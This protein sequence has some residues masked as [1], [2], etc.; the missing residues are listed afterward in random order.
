MDWKKPTD[1]KINKK[2]IPAAKQLQDLINNL[3]NTIKKL[4]KVKKGL[5]KK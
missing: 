4:E 1:K 2:D 3:E 5:D